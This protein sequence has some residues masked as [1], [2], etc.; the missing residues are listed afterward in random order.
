MVSTYVLGG[1]H[2][3]RRR[4]RLQDGFAGRLPVTGAPGSTKNAQRQRDP[5]MHQRRK[6]QQWYSGMKLHIGVDSRSGPAHG[7]VVTAANV[8][9]KHPVPQLPQGAGQRVCGDSAYA[10]QKPL[11]QAKA[12]LA[13]D[14]TNPRSRKG[15]PVHEA[16]R[17][18]NRTKFRV[19][20]RVEHV[21]GVVKR[22][23][24]FDKVRYR[25]PARNA[26]RSFVALALANTF[27]ARRTLYGQVRPWRPPSGPMTRSQ[28]EWASDGS[29]MRLESLPQHSQCRDFES[30]AQ[31]R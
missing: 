12:P 11:N 22:L 9:D 21:F 14:C 13:R 25:G 28:A 16:L 5:E 17:K 24:R 8:H 10:R 26:T 7:A 2:P 29:A 23:W 6:G 3:C 30:P 15:C 18:K 27:L 19:R 4:A 31:C 1:H 20:A